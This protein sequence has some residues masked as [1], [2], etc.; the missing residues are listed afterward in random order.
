MGEPYPFYRVPF[1]L[2]AKAGHSGIWKR[3][4]AAAPRASG[5]GSFRQF[6]QF[7]EVEI[8]NLPRCPELAT[9]L[10]METFHPI[11]LRL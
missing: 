2:R 8:N 9:E 4:P 1:S 6:A 5:R 7:V 11:G 10:V 3:S